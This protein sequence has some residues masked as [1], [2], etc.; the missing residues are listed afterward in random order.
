MQ[1]AYICLNSI[2]V[3]PHIYNWIGHIL[4]DESLLT[5]VIGGQMIGKRPR[6]R[7]RL[8]TL[9]GFLKEALYA[10]LERKAENRKENGEHG[11]QAPT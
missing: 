6:G 9:K 5:E 11:S 1:C 7:K 4:R 10:E 8:G 3:H 2:H